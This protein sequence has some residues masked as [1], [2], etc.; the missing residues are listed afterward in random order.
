MPTFSTFISSNLPQ[1]TALRKIFT[2]LNFIFDLCPDLISDLTR[3]VAI[4]IENIETNRNIGNDLLL[5]KAF[6]EFLNNRSSN[7]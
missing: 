5:R 6:Q 3:E 1:R 7:K 4:T 2:V